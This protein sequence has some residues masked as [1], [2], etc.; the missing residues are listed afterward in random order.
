MLGFK[1]IK[2][3]TVKIIIYSTISLFI[4]GGGLYSGYFLYNNFYRTI[5]YIHGDE[6]LEDSWR[7][8][9]VDM[10]KF[11]RIKDRLNEKKNKS[12]QVNVSMDF[13]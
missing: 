3:N 4:I 9:F 7:I 8:E 12:E 1:N 11:E 10:E 6:L 13:Y 2:F 5:I